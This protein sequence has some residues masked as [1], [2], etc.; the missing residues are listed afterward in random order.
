MTTLADLRVGWLAER[1]AHRLGGIVYYFERLDEAV[2][3]GYTDS[4][5]RRR[6]KLRRQHGPL[7][8]IA[9]EPGDPAHERLRHEQF[10]HLRIAPIPEW[11]NVERDLYEHIV[12]LRAAL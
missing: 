5:A 10:A 3:I 11:F 4:Y 8:L 12:A 6:A 1:E 9:W 7:R 2:K